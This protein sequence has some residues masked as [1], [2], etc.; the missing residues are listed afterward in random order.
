MVSRRPAKPLDSILLGARSFAFA[1]AAAFFPVFPIFCA[2]PFR[3]PRTTGAP[4]R[5]PAGFWIRLAASSASPPSTAARIRC[6]T[7]ARASGPGLSKTTAT[8]YGS[9]AG[10]VPD[11]R[12]GH[13][14]RRQFRRK[15]DFRFVSHNPY[16]HAAGLFIS[17]LR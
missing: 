9:N 2:S 17:V 16:L 11:E 15:R 14:L 7:K 4:A 1:C 5:C 12:L 13:L 3:R 8:R 6:E 10:A